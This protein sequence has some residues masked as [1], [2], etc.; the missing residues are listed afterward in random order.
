MK[1]FLNNS[2]YLF[3]KWNCYERHYFKSRLYSSRSTKTLITPY[4]VYLSKT[5]Q[6][7]IKNGNNNFLKTIIHIYHYK[8]K[9]N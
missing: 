2:I 7:T 8:R 9:Q 1:K 3:P 5:P 4:C 6:K